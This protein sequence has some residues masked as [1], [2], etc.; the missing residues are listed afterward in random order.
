M[1]YKEVVHTVLLYGREIWVLTGERLKFMEGLHHQVDRQI[2]GKTVFC[3]VDIE[4][5]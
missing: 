3:M 4:W 1:V 2:A 5:E